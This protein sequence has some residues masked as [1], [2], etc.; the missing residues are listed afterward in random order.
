MSQIHP[1]LFSLLI[2]TLGFSVLAGLMSVSPAAFAFKF[3]PP[4]QKPTEKPATETSKAAKAVVETVSPEFSVLMKAVDVLFKEKKY[5]EA[6]DK[7][8]EVEKLPKLTPLESYYATHW[9]LMIALN[10]RNLELAGVTLDVLKT[11]ERMPQTEKLDYTKKI[12]ALYYE[13]KNYPKSIEWITRY[14]NEGGDDPSYRLRLIQAY[15]NNGDFAIVAKEL[16]ENI[17]AEENAGKTPSEAQLTM[18]LSSSLKLGDKAAYRYPLEKLVAY[19]PNEEYWNNL[20]KVMPN[21][22][23]MAKRLDLDYYRFKFA[24]GELKAAPEFV[25][26]SLLALEAGW[27]A[28]A[29][30]II[31]AGYS[32]KILGAGPHAPEHKRLADEAAKKQAKETPAVLKKNEVDAQKNKEGSA[33]FNL[34]YAYVT[35]GQSSKGIAFMEEGLARGGMKRPEDAKLHLGYAYIQNK[36]KEKATEILKTVQG[37]DGTADLA[38]LWV[39]YLNPPAPAPVVAAVPVLVATSAAVAPTPAALPAP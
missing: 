2:A 21:K 14:F 6:L 10:A 7:I 16:R 20:F 27:P 35:T 4:K 30:K 23:T 3:N 33:L 28:E 9:R 39:L 34:G 1:K 26:L 38:R 24:L 36:Q 11:S 25:E 32:A 13:A 15:Y 37:E 17:D 31:A 18:L 29:K 22:T 19:Y 12:A 5:T 8:A